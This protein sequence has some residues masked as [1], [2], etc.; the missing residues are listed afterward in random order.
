MKKTNFFGMAFSLLFVFVLC[1]AAAFAQST[2]IDNPT[3]VTQSVVQGK[4]PGNTEEP[5]VYY[6]TFTAGPGVLKVT[7]DQKSDGGI[8]HSNLSWALTDANFNAIA[9]EAFYGVTTLERKVN[10]IKL[11]KKQKVI[12][13][14]EVTEDVKLFKFQFTGAVAFTPAQSG[15][16]E[17][18]PEISGDTTTQSTQQICM[19]RN[20]V[21]IMTMKDGKKAKVDLSKVQKIEIQ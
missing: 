7:A 9:S 2:D 1:S 13:K 16:N 20:G 15:G 19:P 3:V 8:S 14:V 12:L 5:V 11:T 4:H 21:I 18:I 6:Y 10:E 17:N